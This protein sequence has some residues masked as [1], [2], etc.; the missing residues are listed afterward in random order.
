[1]QLSLEQIKDVA[2]ELTAPERAELA[3]FLVRSLD[4]HEVQSIR[5]EWLK[6]ARR[7]M[8]EIKSGKAVTVPADEVLRT[9]LDATK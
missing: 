4:E 5:T 9:L 6:V 2:V 1:M 8:D 7:R 3:Q